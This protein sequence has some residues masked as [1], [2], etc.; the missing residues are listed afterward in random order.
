MTKRVL[1]TGAAGKVAAVLR[2]YLLA[3]FDELVLTDRWQPKDIAKNE[4]FVMADL[5]DPEQALTA[6]K[7]IDAIVHLAG[8]PGEGNWDDVFDMSMRPTA[9]ILE[10]AQVAGVERFVFASSNHVIGY[11]PRSQRLGGGEKVLP[12]SRYAVA[13]VFGEAALALYADK[14]AMKCF[15]IRIGTVIDRPRILRELAT[16]H[17]PEDLAQLIAIGVNHP[18]IRNDIVW[19]IS[20]NKRSWWDNSRATAL[21]YRPVHR[22]EDHV[23]FATEGENHQVPDPVSDALQ[24]GSMA[25]RDFV[26]DLK[27]LGAENG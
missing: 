12:D 16:F 15:S 3:R 27:D 4:H 9:N 10:T 18:D 20:D 23:A 6:C 19:G 24:G 13:K 14:Y 8:L 26:A 5:L 7:D 21:G 11:Y 22:A 25:S 1:L 2:P 17:H